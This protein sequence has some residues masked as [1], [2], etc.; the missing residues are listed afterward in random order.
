MAIR[1]TQKWCRP[2]PRTTCTIR[3][4]RLIAAAS[5]PAEALREYIWVDD[6]PLAVVAAIGAY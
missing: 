6:L 5:G 1:L 2:A 4:G 3:P